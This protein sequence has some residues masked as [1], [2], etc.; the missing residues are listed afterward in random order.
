MSET[1][2]L[3]A[4][5]GAVV[6]IALLAAALVVARRRAPPDPALLLM[7]Q[8][9]EALRGQVGQSLEGTTRALNER[10]DALQTQVSEALHRVNESLGQRLDANLQ[11]VGQRFS[12]TAGMVT[13]VH[14]KLRGLEEA[15]GR[16]FELAKDLTSLQD[17]LQP[18]K[19][20]GGV[21]E[22]LLENLLRDRLPDAN[23][24][25]QHRFASG[26]FVDAVIRIG[27]RLVPVDSKFPLEAFH[28]VLKAPSDDERGKARREFARQ[29]QGHVK[30]IAE[31]Y[32]LPEEGTYD[33]AL[34]YI[35]A[36]NVY[37]EAVVRADEPGGL[38]GFAME[39]RVIPVSPT[40]FYAYLVALAYGLKGLKVEEQAAQIRAGLAHLTADFE[41][42]REPLGKLGEQLRRAQK[43]YEDADRSL[44]RFGNR[45]AQVSGA[46][47]PQTTP[48]ALPLGDG[49]DS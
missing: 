45:L 26:T 24:Q 33:F 49:P 1:T 6:G 43:N 7:Q 30:S 20:R 40:T 42:V 14:E 37:Y 29:V 34:M 4:V 2:I 9:V 12:E 47:L 28:A 16:I 13:I 15:A 18:P 39:R 36:E 5:V 46:P 38:Y 23:F 25:M 27:G 17:I 48:T 19:M 35:P 44:E 8:Q 22:V 32:I 10:T 11:M 41:R 21:G 31:K 3:A